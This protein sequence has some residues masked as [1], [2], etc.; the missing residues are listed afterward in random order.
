MTQANLNRLD[1][2]SVCEPIPSTGKCGYDAA[3]AATGSTP[4]LAETMPMHDVPTENLLQFS[5]L[6]AAIS[7]QHLS[8]YTRLRLADNR[9]SVNAYPD[10]YGGL[11]YVGVPSYQVPEE[12]DLAAVFALAVRAKVVW[13]KFDRDAGIVDG[14]PLY[15]D[16]DEDEVP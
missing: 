1:S 5:E 8:P 13:L 6:M 9:L 7:T 11:V 16:E 12:P 2:T 14:L 10:E 3:T 15:D 4:Q